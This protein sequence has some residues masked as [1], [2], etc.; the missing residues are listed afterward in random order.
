MQS[1]ERDHLVVIHNQSLLLKGHLRN[2]NIVISVKP[3]CARLLLVSLPR[4]RH[5]QSLAIRNDSG[6]PDLALGFISYFF[7]WPIEQELLYAQALAAR[8]VVA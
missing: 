6:W 7:L 8:S 5:I 4:N 3:E 1:P 2:L